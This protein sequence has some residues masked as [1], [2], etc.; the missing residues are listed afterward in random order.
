V[1][2]AS[3]AALLAVLAV[4]ALPAR[5][6]DPPLR[7][8]VTGDSMMQ[9]LDEILRKPVKRAGG[10]V[11]SDPRPGTGLSNRIAFDWQRHAKRQM[12]RH[13]PRATV[14]LI[15][16]N[17]SYAM[18][19][20]DGREVSCCRRA[21]IDAYAERAARM[22]RTY[23]RRGRAFVYWLTLPTPVEPHRQRFA[24]I[25]IAI[26]QAAGEAGSRVRVVDLVPV[27]SP[28]NRFRRKLRY[29]GRRVVVRDRDGVH[30]TNAGSRIASDAVRRA[31]RR[32]G[33]L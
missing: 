2:P 3:A 29:R 23:R 21:W 14:M 9:P 7:V 1:R 18:R 8:L 13:R 20:A 11:V 33:L 19:G 30:L 22:M 5:A 24:A 28:G 32:D 31:M 27:L 16:P 10:R 6:A 26:E 17:D 12:R 4:L 25:N 15:G